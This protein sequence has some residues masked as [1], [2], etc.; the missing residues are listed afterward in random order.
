MAR[1]FYIARC[2]GIDDLCIGRIQPN[3]TANIVSAP[4]DTSGRV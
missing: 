1:P 4:C 3:Q 2:I